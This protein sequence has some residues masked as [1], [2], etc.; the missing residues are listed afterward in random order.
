MKKAQLKKQLYTVCSMD[1]YTSNKDLYNSKFTAIENENTGVVLPLRGSTDSAPGIYYQDDAMVCY[2]NKPEDP[3]NYS[4]DN[5]IDFS[6]PK[7]IDEIFEKNQLI[8]DIRNDIPA[9]SDDIFYLKIGEADTPEMKALKNAIN[10]K[11]VDRKQYEDRFDQYQNDMRLLRGSTITLSKLVSICTAF[12]ISADLTLR[13]R[14]Y[15][16]PNPMNTE[17]T[18][19]LT[20]GRE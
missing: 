9:T 2:V 8:R 6:N 12:D 13:D 17:I 16:I 1:E 10:I 7:S 20:E 19:D 18:V 15:D 14:S 11:Q 3:E 4:T 5:I